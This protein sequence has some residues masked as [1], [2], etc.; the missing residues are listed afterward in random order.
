[1]KFII[2]GAGDVG[3]TLAERLSTSNQEVTIIEKNEANAARV[4]SLI[5]AKII[6]GNGCDPKL[7]ESAN[8][9]YADYF[10]SV[11]DSDEVNIAAGLM[12]KLL[13]TK[14]KR[15]ARIRHIN[16]NDS[17][18]SKEDLDDCFDLII[19]PDRAGADQLVRLF[20][21]PA[22]SD[23]VQFVNGKLNVYGLQI[24]P[25]S[26]CHNLAI[27]DL[28]QVFNSKPILIISILRNE[29]IIVPHGEDKLYSGDTIYA[30]TLP[31]HTDELFELAGH[32]NKKS[33]NAVVWGGTVLGHFV[34]SELQ[35]NG[36]DIKLILEEK[37][38]NDELLDCFPE[39]LVLQ[40]EGTDQR[41][42][43]EENIAS[44][45]AFIA[46]SEHEED[47]VLAALLA[48]KLGAK[49]VMALVNKRTYMDLVSAIGVDAV[50]S[51]QFAAASAI[52][53]HI[54]PDAIFSDSALN[55]YDTNF[56]EV[57]LQPE[58]PYVG[59]TIKDLNLP[60]NVLIIAIVRNG[61]IL[62]P[63]GNDLIE[64]Y[65]SVVIFSRR[66][67]LKKLSKQMAIKLDIAD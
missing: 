56:I 32:E 66:K 12:A 38:L 23:I 62:I 14:V 26:Q 20:N 48:K 31:K 39:C 61:N 9:A 33:K 19:N 52:F 55:V 28:P 4:S 24:L 51:T 50:V 6:I 59:K 58:M 5:D 15:I 40:G 67:Q 16:L 43:E 8:I 54:H 47:N 17:S 34:T 37:L 41:L 44:T 10:I 64:A 53:K 30:V 3:L 42:L 60:Q 13:N 46:A 21:A 63:K 18:I 49:K 22:A 11:A 57:K 35:S 27:K 2:V 7:L 65:D 1:M 25:N 29:Q 45:D 36:V